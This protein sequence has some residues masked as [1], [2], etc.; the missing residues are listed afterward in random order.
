M[1]DKK[2]QAQ[3]EDETTIDLLELFF[4]ILGR[5]KLV[6]LAM[7][8]SAGLAGGYHTL[9]IE[10]SYQA[11]AQMYITNTESVISFSDLQLSSALAAD[12]TKIIKSRNVLK[13][14]INE[15]ELD[16]D[17]KDLGNLIRIEN[18]DDTH[19]IHIYVTCNDKKLARNIANTLLNISID[20][21]Y[22]IV[23]NSEPTVIDRAEADA[24]EE[25]M[26]SLIKYVVLGAM[27]GMLFVC[28]LI[29][30]ITMMN[31]S[32]KTTED[33]EHYLQLPVLSAVPYYEHNEKKTSKS[34]RE[35]KR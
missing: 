30:V 32:L 3:F 35:Q 11:D 27:F 22:Q 17:F 1:E 21:I 28:A 4:E 7:L 10:P 5:W 14:V 26:P 2:V 16:M 33:V 8:L 19:I 20:Q 18:P 23:G 15:L 29:A 13:R 25:L 6:V 9:F 34:K 24:V 31:T 12:Y